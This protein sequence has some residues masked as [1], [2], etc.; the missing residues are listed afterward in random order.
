MAT[1]VKDKN[2]VHVN[3]EIHVATQ[4]SVHLVVNV[5]ADV[6]NQPRRIVER[7]TTTI[8]A[9]SVPRG[10]PTMQRVEIVIIGNR[11]ALHVGNRP[12]RCDS[13]SRLLGTYVDLFRSLKPVVHNASL[14]GVTTVGGSP[15]WHV[16]ASSKVTVLGTTSNM[17]TDLFVSERD[18]TL[19]QM[20]AGLTLADRAGTVRE[21][22]IERLS[23]YGERVN[24]TLPSSCRA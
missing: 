20:Y 5:V 1:S 12:W 3:M 16:R 11:G 22:V 8:S 10:I 15:S 7:A 19:V 17:P 24:V 4:Q 18:Y 2:S 21:R 14:A 13:V 23:R 9:V 6:Q